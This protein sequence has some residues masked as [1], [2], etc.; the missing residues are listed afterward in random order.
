MSELDD[1]F[2]E[3]P[4]SDARE[5]YAVPDARAPLPTMRPV[6][7]EDDP[8]LCGDAAKEA[9]AKARSALMGER[10]NHQRSA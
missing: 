4:S 10:T 6:A 7:N 8:I 2:D 5:L 3:A 9:V 1:L